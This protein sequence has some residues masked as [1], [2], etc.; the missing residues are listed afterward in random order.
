MDGT[1]IQFRSPQT[2]NE[3]ATCGNLTTLKLRCHFLD[4]TR[5]K[6]PGKAKFHG[7]NLS[8]FKCGNK[9]WGVGRGGGEGGGYLKDHWV[10]TPSSPSLEGPHP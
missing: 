2:G 7:Q 8:Y 4:M 9:G 1:W 5:N 6:D 3:F 10:W